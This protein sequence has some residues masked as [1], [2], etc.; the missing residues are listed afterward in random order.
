MW[1]TADC[2]DQCLC[3][4]AI[5]DIIVRQ[6]ETGKDMY[7]I[8]QGAVEVSGP[9]SRGR[10][11]ARGVKDVQAAG[12][13]E[14]KVGNDRESKIQGEGAHRRLTLVCIAELMQDVCN[15]V[16]ACGTL[17]TPPH[18]PT[19]THTPTCWQARVYSEDV[20]LVSVVRSESLQG[21]SADT[22]KRRASVLER[23]GL[24]QQPADEEGQGRQSKRLVLSSSDVMHLHYL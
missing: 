20:Q 14:G 16:S 18:I 10:R 22:S 21:A 11:G 4:T 17:H 23:L 5:G 24:M 15:S 2:A 9:G 7:F 1:I 8:G 19:Q 13:K 3:C 12:A 6:G